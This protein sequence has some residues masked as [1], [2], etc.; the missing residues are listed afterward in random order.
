VDSIGKFKGRL[1]VAVLWQDRDARIPCVQGVYVVCAPDGY[2]P[3]FLKTSRGGRF[4][5]DPTM[6]VAKLEKLWV[7]GT[8]ILYIGKTGGGKSKRRTLCKRIRELLDF[9][10]GNPKARHWGGRALWQLKGAEQFVISWRALPDED[11]RAVEKRMIADFK[12][13]FGGKRPFANLRG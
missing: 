3:T 6:P 10:E 11:P 13:R 5:G 4:R 7:D 9:G 1:S 2:R 12:Q 8:P